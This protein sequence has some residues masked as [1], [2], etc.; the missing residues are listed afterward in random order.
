MLP[1]PGPGRWLMSL[2]LAQSAGSGLFLTSSALLFVHVLGIPAA[3]VGIGLSVAGL[4]GFAAV[5]PV[6]KL[7]DRKGPRR[8]LKLDHT[9]LAAVFVVLPFVR[10]FVPFVL[11]CSL[12]SIGELCGSPLRSAVIH[13]TVGPAEAVRTRAQLRSAFNV[14]FMAGAGV[15]GLLLL[16]PGTTALT[17]VC[18]GNVAAQLGCRAIVQRLGADPEPR[19]AGGRSAVA[20]TPPATRPALRDVRFVLITLC[21]GLLELH[22]TVLAVGMPLWIAERTGAPA[23][24]NAVLI[25]MNTLLVLVFQV[26]LSRGGRT[27]LG[28][29][30]LQRRA[31]MLLAAGCAVCAL[32]QGQQARGA[33]PILVLGAAAL[34]LG[35]IMQSAGAWG[36]SFELPPSGRQAEYQSVF[37]LGR[38]VQQFVGPALVTSVLIGGG[39]VGWLL[40]ALMFVVL[41]VLCVRLVT[42]RWGRV[43]VDGARVEQPA[44]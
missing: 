38:A 29:A 4:I 16:A 11:V 30:A 1:D 42:G 36:L 12:I 44:A 26:R 10:G 43:T 33:V 28:A 15:A 5:V 2:T 25:M 6:G 20:G 7:A 41:G 3:Q 31:G 34:A 39:R 17:A 14:G 27:V 24:L 21:N 13:A 9:A 18:A 35:E 37:A 32:S 22:T 19:T 8:L 23:A 40:L